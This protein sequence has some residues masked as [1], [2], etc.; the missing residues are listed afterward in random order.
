M[1]W[2]EKLPN[3]IF[4]S[5]VF[6]HCT[7]SEIKNCLLSFNRRKAVDIWVM[8]AFFYLTGAICIWTLTSCWPDR[9]SVNHC[10][11]HPLA[12]SCRVSEHKP[13]GASFQ[14]EESL[15]IWSS[16]KSRPYVLFT[17]QDAAQNSLKLSTLEY[18]PLQLP[19]NNQFL[20][21]AIWFPLDPLSNKYCAL[22]WPWLTWGQSC[23]FTDRQLVYCVS[24]RL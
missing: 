23:T 16:S 8:Q 19:W 10:S 13:E 1:L 9:H 14:S 17:D 5:L 21:G 7:I 15:H 12:P 6:Q 18:G 3:Q 11:P 22:K 2:W 4:R 24:T 20:W